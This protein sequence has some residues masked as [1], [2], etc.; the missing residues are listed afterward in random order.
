MI[1]VNYVI[2]P[3]RRL[4]KYQTGRLKLFDFQY[5]TRIVVLTNNPVRIPHDMTYMLLLL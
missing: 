5:Y 3:I 2:I 4:T 1:L